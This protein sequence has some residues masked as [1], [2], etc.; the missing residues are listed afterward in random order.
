M[1]VLGKIEKAP[2][3]DF[4]KKNSKHGWQLVPHKAFKRVDPVILAQLK[5]LPEVNRKDYREYLQNNDI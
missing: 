3:H 2:A 5:P 1:Q 4:T